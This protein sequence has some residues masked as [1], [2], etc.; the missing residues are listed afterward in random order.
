MNLAW[1]YDGVAAAVLLLY[2]LRGARGGLAHTVMRL[3]GSLLALAA[4]WVFSE[5]V[6][7]AVYQG[8][9]RRQ[10]LEVLAQHLGGSLDLAALEGQVTAAVSQLPAVVANPVNALVDG[11][12]AL[13][14]ESLQGLEGSHL[15]EQVARLVIDPAVTAFLRV[16]AFLVIYALCACGVRLLADAFRW[17]NHIPLIGSVNQVLGALL[18]AV[19]GA[20]ALLLGCAFLSFVGMATGGRWALLDA[21]MVE[22][23]HLLRYFAGDTF[24][25]P[26]QWAQLPFETEK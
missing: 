20:V 3:L 7:G 23:T 11:Q 26:A 10:V 25:Q 15:W 2:I 1:V 14:G 8:F 6:A 22:Q 13:L 12:L 19:Q 5:A 9:L 24:A 17:V 21:R 4:A 16:I 18:G